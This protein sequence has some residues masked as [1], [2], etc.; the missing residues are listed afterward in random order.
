[1]AQDRGLQVLGR[2]ITGKADFDLGRQVAVIIG[3]DKYK[4]WPS[5]R[6]AVAEAK[7]V[8]K[9]LAERYVIDEFL[10][11]YDEDATAAN[12]RRL[13]I[14]TLPKRLGAKDSLLVFYAGHC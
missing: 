13:F 10:E 1:M 9:V 2:E 8:S 4:E 12:I 5:L 6:A 11:L 14:E 3:I 7:T